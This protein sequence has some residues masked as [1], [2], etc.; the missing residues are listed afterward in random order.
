MG[1]RRIVLCDTNILFHLFHR[2]SIIEDELNEIGFGSLA[3]SSVTVAETIYGMRKKEERKTK[4]L[5]RRFH[6][7]HIDKDTSVK[8]LELMSGYR[9]PRMKIPDALIAATALVNNF[10]LFTLNRKDFDFVEGLRLYNPTRK[11]QP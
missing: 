11:I 7:V 8:L 5:L 2:D 10:P 3:I 1:T 4:E 6:C 9:S